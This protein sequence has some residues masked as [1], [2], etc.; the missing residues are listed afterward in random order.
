[1]KV[2][3]ISFEFWYNYGTCLQAYALQEAVR[4]LRVDVEY[5][6]P[7]WRYTISPIVQLLSCAHYKRSRISI[8]HR[9]G[10]CYIVLRDILRRKSLAPLKCLRIASRN[11][12][13]FDK[14]RFAYLR[15]SADTNLKTVNP[16]YDFFMVGSD[17]TWNPNCVSEAHFTRFLL[18]FVEDD[19]KKT[20]YAPSVGMTGVDKKTRD[21]FARYLTSFKALSCRE[22]RGATLISEATG[23]DVTPVL[24]PTFLL[25]PVEW[26]CVAKPVRVPE[27]YVLCYLLGGKTCVLSYARRLAE[28]RGVELVVLSNNQHIVEQCAGSIVAGVGPAEFV[29]LIDNAKEVV[30]DSFHGTAFA[31]NFNKPMHSFIKR[32]GDVSVSDNSRIIDMLAMFKL[33]ERFRLDDDELNVTACDFTEANLVLKS[34][35]KKSLDYLMAALGIPGGMV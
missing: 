8:Y 1:M 30:T 10:A 9:L 29:Y 11:S 14:F 15:I 32:S 17:Q 19:C 33:A 2:A 23:R 31:V 6:D 16:R 21:L 27:T 18:D 26:R 13:A 3:L 4:K 25:T 7:G 35:R 34:E 28:E 12:E 5:F 20:S 22:S 24:D